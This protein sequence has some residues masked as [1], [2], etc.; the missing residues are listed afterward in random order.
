MEIFFASISNR[1][2][3]TAFLVIAVLLYCMVK[4]KDVIKSLLQVLRLIFFS[5]LTMLFLIPTV[6]LIA[7]TCLMF[8]CNVWDYTLLKDTIFSIVGG[9][10]LF[11]K[12]IGTDNFHK[13]Y[14]DNIV[15]YFSA[16]YFL[17]F[18]VNF[19]DFN[20]FIEI[21]LVAFVTLVCATST[22]MEYSTEE[23]QNVKE[24]KQL[25]NG[26]QIFIGAF[27]IIHSS[28]W[29]FKEPTQLFNIHSLQILLL[30]IIYTLF[31]YPICFAI[32]VYA[33]YETILTSMYVV[34]DNL[35]KQISTLEMAY[36]TFKLC[37]TNIKQLK[38]WQHFFLSNFGGCEKTLDIDGLIQEFQWRYKYIE[39][40]KNT[41][42]IALNTALEFM[43]EYNFPKSLYKYSTYSDGYGHYQALA[44][45][46]ESS[47][48]YYC[49]NGNQ[50]Y[51]QFFML[52]DFLLTSQNIKSELKLFSTYCNALY[53]KI[54]SSELKK[55]EISK[56]KQLKKFS[57][58]SGLYT[59]EFDNDKNVNGK[60]MSVTF[61]ISKILPVEKCEYELL[62][63]L[64]K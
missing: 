60:I 1:E 22:Y 46:K 64:Q 63:S 40:E 52:H 39:P 28:I 2:Y 20:I 54:F 21:V 18:F 23:T 34:R 16:I 14:K 45:N 6:Y 32:Y 53:L 26:I 17:E 15:G 3:A 37:K 11:G 44:Y 33:K 49:V 38:L 62:F 5:K 36:K 10:L 56:I 47:N 55:R 12:A 13:I 58:K 31:L 4:S 42:E 61:K 25:L 48:R 9:L 57:Y 7:I 50:Q 41:T 35:K 8:K 51:P 27:I 19:H 30:P 24:A 43:E 29:M 59:V